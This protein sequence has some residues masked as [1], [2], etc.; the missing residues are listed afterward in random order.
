MID[1]EEL[2]ARSLDEPLTPDERV[3]LRVWADALEDAGDPRGPLIAMEHALREQPWREHELRQAMNEHV[4]ANAAHL[5][6]EIAPFARFKRGLSLDWRS[7]Q[8]YGAFFDT[9]YLA[10]Q[11][12][13]SPSKLVTMLLGAP[14]MTTLRR[15]HVRVRFEAQVTE[16]IRVLYELEHGLPLEELRVLTGVRVT[17]IA[18]VD[19]GPA[20]TGLLAD[21]YPGLRLL[22]A[23]ARGSVLS[24]SAPR[25][26]QDDARLT[27]LVP[28]AAPN[29]SDGRRT[30]GLALIQPEPALRTQALVRLTELG[31]RAFMFVES[32]MMLLEPGIVAPQAPIAACLPALGDH[33]RIA[34]PM[35]AAITGR[36][37]HYDRETRRAAGVASARLGA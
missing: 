7:G 25:T 16:V 19:R 8:L 28:A 29:T 27:R 35:L 32:L 22:A 23:G 11:T 1:F 5:L 37:A 34:L 10:E 33:A 20:S 17:G 3:V 31:E 9:R 6:G 12:K 26:Q 2:A 18:P 30:L 21:R 15:L 13:L 4:V 36:A 24:L 14:A